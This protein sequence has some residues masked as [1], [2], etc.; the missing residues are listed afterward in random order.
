MPRKFLK[1]IMP[2]HETMREHPHL[3]KFG[4]RLTEPRLW[5]LNRRSVAG[6]M[7]LGL[8]VGFMPVLGQ[9]FIAAALAIWLRVNLPVA[10]MA[11]WVTNPFTFAPIFFYSYKLGAWIL[12][13][14]MGQYAFSP[15]WEWFSY[16]FLKIWQPLLL[17]CTILGLLAALV[18][19]LFVRIGWRL[20]VIRSWIKRPH[21]H[22]SRS[23][24]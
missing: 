24:V 17:G 22:N 1:R 16:E 21:K 2:D 3:R 4:Q 23:G 15:T 5:H 19:V 20:V 18:G 9:M 6:G 7:A 14:P 12:E 8:F 11:V 10:S 13:V